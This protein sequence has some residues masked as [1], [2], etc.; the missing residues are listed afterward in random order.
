MR[1]RFSLSLAAFILLAGFV[2]PM[3]ATASPEGD[4]ER[5]YAQVRKIALKDP[6]VQAAFEKA[7]ARLDEKILKID[8]ALKPIVEREKHAPAPGA[9]GKPEIE[10]VPAAA[11]ATPEGRQHVVVKGETLS[12][13][14]ARYKVKVAALEKLNH[15]TDDRKLQVGQKLAIPTATSPAPESPAP[16]AAAAETPEPQPRD[17]GGIW[18][19]LKSNL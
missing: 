9:A 17:N 10:Q 13:I 11:T 16:P 15:I 8:P 1:I 7:N 6:G 14:A 18:D 4:L 12:S 3:A 5:E 19:R 2:R